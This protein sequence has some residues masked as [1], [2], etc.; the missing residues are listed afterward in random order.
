M[1]ESVRDMASGRKAKGTASSMLLVPNGNAGEARARAWQAGALGR[2][3]RMLVVHTFGAIGPSEDGPLRTGHFAFG[4]GTIADE[5]LT[6][7]L[8][9]DVEYKQV[10]AHNPNGIIAGSHDYASFSGS[11]ARGW[12]YSRPLAEVALVL[13]ALNRE[14]AFGS[15]TLGA[16]IVGLTDELEAMTAR[17]RTGL[18]TGGAIVTPANSCVQDSSKALYFA[19]AKLEERANEPA[20]KAFVNAH[21][22]DAAVKDFKQVLAL[23][24]DVERYLSP[25][26]F[27]RGDWKS[28]ANKLAAT[29]VSACPGGL[30]GA[31]F[32]G[33]ASF[34]TVVPRRASDFY[35]E[36]LILAGAGGIAI[37]TNDVGGTMGTLV[38]LSPTTLFK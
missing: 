27:T 9:F 6:G 10:Y 12:M 21:P 3:A 32:C 19:L 33:L 24:N 26:G 34:G 16:P 38:P 4:V 15:T 22:D 17:Y 37:R 20:V 13:P 1:W 11:F 18:G 35:T 14:Y 8:A 2:G 36:T 30:V 25:L 7:E 29:D 28:Q 5:P 31:A 23:A